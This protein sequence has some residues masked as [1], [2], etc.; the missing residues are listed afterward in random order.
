ML[1]QLVYNRA[2]QETSNLISIFKMLEKLLTNSLQR[3]ILVYSYLYLYTVTAADG[4]Q[5]FPDSD[6]SKLDF[7]PPT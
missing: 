4:D 5:G 7:F 2:F 3:I 1:I 6:W